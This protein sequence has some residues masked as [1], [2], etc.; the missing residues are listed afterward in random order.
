LSIN[1]ANNGKHAMIL[2]CHLPCRKVHVLSNYFGAR[3]V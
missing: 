1:I 2:S 3:L